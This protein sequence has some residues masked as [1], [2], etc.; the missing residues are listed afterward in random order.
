MREKYD[1]VEKTNEIKKEDSKI[2][3]TANLRR[4]SEGF[5]AE[6][7]NT[8]NGA[9]HRTSEQYHAEHD[10]AE[11]AAD[12]TSFQFINIQ[13]KYIKILAETELNAKFI[14]EITGYCK[15]AVE[16]MWSEVALADLSMN[17]VVYPNIPLI[18]LNVI[19]FKIVPLLAEYID[20]Q[21]ADDAK[22]EKGESII[23]TESQLIQFIKE[24]NKFW[25]KNKVEYKSHENEIQ[26]KPGKPLL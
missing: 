19:G 1:R 2:Q 10:V 7:L 8:K 3:S 26:C 17:R 21:R 13:R 25:P 24:K 12:I 9:F 15:K 4:I 11:I 20:K 18:P 5:K 14:N 16:E 6:I 22:C 23:P